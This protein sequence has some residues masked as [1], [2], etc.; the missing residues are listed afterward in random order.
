MNEKLIEE[1]KKVRDIPYYIPLNVN[2]N[3]L[4]CSGKH[5]ILAKKFS[6]LGYKIR[7]RV[8]SFSWDTL[9][10]QKD[11]ISVPHENQCTHVFLEIMLENKWVIIDA[12]WDK[13]LS[14]I[15]HINDWDGKSNT[16]IAVPVLEIYSPEKSEE[17]MENENADV[18][19]KDL[20]INGE[21]YK[22]FNNYLNSVRVKQ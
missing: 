5:R 12:T 20:K 4:C 3:D 9:I 15:F 10:S 19:E 21:F 18:I 11:I 16:K 8:C 6:D 13:G 22:S 2:E 17:I 7:Y 1:F 14:Q